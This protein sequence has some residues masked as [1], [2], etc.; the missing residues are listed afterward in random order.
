MSKFYVQGSAIQVFEDDAVTLYDDLPVNMYYL[1]VNPKTGLYLEKTGAISV[2][3]DIFGSVEKHADMIIDTFDSKPG[4]MG[5]LLSGTKGTGKTC[6]SKLVAKK[7]LAKGCPVIMV[8]T[9]INTY[10]LAEFFQKI[11]TK[12]MILFDEF[13]KQYGKQEKSSDD[14]DDIIAAAGTNQNGLLSLLDGIQSAKQLFMFVCNELEEVNEYLF[15]RPSRIYYHIKYK[16]LDEDVIRSYCEKYLNNKDYIEDILK[17][18]YVVNDL[19]FDIL[20]AIVEESNRYNMPP[21]ATLEFLNVTPSEESRSYEIHFVNIKTGE[22]YDT[23]RDI[24][25]FYKK[26]CTHINLPSR[27]NTE[28]KKPKKGKKGAEDDDDRGDWFLSDYFQ[29]KQEYITS[30]EDGNIIYEMDD[31]KAE[32]TRIDEAEFDY[33]KMAF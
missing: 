3:D 12:S 22:S 28:Y 7:M 31:W 11:N 14:D 5:V 25:V 24:D 2:P 29:F 30:M 8:T 13:D 9:G 19:S 23:K 32:A 27:M 33:R 6:T 20:Q 16:G 17:V 18:R 21:S 15:N 10:A 26:R 4:N 1:R